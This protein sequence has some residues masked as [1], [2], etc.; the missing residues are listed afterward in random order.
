MN[1]GSGNKD[2]EYSLSV[3][4]KDIWDNG[5]GNIVQVG[6]VLTLVLGQWKIKN[7]NE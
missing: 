3:D 6:R 1:R 4:N 5:K 2:D 7:C